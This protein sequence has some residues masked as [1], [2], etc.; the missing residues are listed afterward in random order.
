M[1]RRKKLLLLATIVLLAV[2][3]LWG[4]AVY[5]HI[6][7]YYHPERDIE[8]LIEKWGLREPIWFWGNGLILTISGFILAF[9]WIFVITKWWTVLKE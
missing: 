2:T 8:K 9:A 4:M 7:A 3:I 6:Q 1:Q 5:Q